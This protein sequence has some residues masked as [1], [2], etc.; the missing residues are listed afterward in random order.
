MAR[1][2]AI[3]CG[4]AIGLPACGGPSK[5]ASVV[6]PPLS[7]RSDLPRVSVYPTLVMPGSEVIVMT[8]PL[9]LLPA[10]EACL[11]IVD[12][13]GFAW[14]ETCGDTASRRVPFRPSKVGRHIAYLYYPMADGPLH[15][16]K[17]RAEF[18][19]LGEQ[20]DCP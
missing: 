15:L 11:R 4:L 19:V 16:T 14:H 10:V 3:V 2:M 9:K 6:F 7:Y 13:D 20:A 18:C 8:R 12:G 1:L 17:D 5:P